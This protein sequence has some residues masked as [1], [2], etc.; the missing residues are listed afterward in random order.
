MGIVDVDLEKVFAR[1]NQDSLMECLTK[2][3]RGC[4]GSSSPRRQCLRRSAVPHGQVPNRVSGAGVRRS[5]GP[6]ALHANARE[7][8]PE[9]WTGST[10]DW[11]PIRG[12]PQSRE[13]G[14]RRHGG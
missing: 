9:R 12:E 6:S 5:G 1:V 11:S 10:W 4:V 7:R 3:R 8:H 14:C 13:R 2:P